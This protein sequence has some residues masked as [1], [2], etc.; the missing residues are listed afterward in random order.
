MRLRRGSS[1]G[2][3]KAG[4]GRSGGTAGVE[5]KSAYRGDGPAYRVRCAEGEGA[6]QGL[7]R[8]LW[9]TGSAAAGI[10]PRGEDEGEVQ[11]GLCL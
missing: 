6:Y 10:V 5:R 7:R 3:G 1:A 11:G 8:G 4:R 2:G 9:I